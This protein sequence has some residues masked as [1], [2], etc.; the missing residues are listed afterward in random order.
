MQD[1]KRSPLSRERRRQKRRSARLAKAA[2][3]V[4]GLYDMA[5]RLRYIG[6]TRCTLAVRLAFHLKAAATPSSP[7]ERWIAA[8]RA[9][10]RKPRIRLIEGAAAWDVSEVIWI[11]RHRVAGADLLNVTRG[12]R[13]APSR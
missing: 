12:G 1:R 6:Q 5:G 11:E 10:G 2:C 13:D 8:E 3:A 4:Y 7:V 9:E